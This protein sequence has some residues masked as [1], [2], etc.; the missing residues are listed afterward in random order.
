LRLAAFIVD[1]PEGGVAN[2]LAVVRPPVDADL[3][4]EE[5]WRIA[6]NVSQGMVFGKLRSQNASFQPGGLR[7]APAPGQPGALPTANPLEDTVPFFPGLHDPL[8][9]VA[10]R[11]ADFQ[12]LRAQSSIGASPSLRVPAVGICRLEVAFP[13]HSLELATHVSENAA[14]R[15]MQKSVSVWDVDEDAVSLALTALARLLNKLPPEVRNRIGRLEVGTESNVD[16]AKSIKSYLTDLLPGQ[17]EL[18][19]VDNVNACYGGA[20]ALMNTCDWLRATAALDQEEGVEDCEAME[21]RR[22][23]V[24]VSTDTAIMD[25]AEIGF[26]GAGAVAVLVGYNPAIEILPSPVAEMK[27]TLD[28]LKPKVHDHN[29]LT[30]RMRSRESMDHYLAALDAVTHKTAERF[31]GWSLPEVQGCVLHGGLCKSVVV[32]AMN[33]WYK[34][35]GATAQMGRAALLAKYEPGTKHGELLG[36]LY[37]ASL[38]FGIHS[39]VEHGKIETGDRLLLFAY[40]SG[41][42]A[43]LLRALVHRQLDDFEPIAPR[44]AARV[45]VDMAATT[46]ALQ[47]HRAEGLFE[48][49]GK[50]VQDARENGLPQGQT[51]EEP[52]RYR[53]V[54]RT[55]QGERKYEV[56]S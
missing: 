34:N 7:A 28:F 36:G 5:A 10:G 35:S 11:D 25:E 18:L 19:G 44:L 52:G 13:A 26:M 24:V 42:T 8:K 40:G 37:T 4:E 16:F 22:F 17:P 46:A 54:E 39:A 43:T 49:L 6:E 55:P 23:G 3:V 30:P 53:L 56:D 48:G 2:T 14:S 51:K 50:T 33:H 41:S 15:L 47:R 1:Q 21:A 27:S 45:P 38:F 29:V 20:A 12:P 9:I 32:K 31:P